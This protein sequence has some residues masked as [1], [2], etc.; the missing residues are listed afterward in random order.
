M[1]W[2]YVYVVGVACIIG[3]KYI[4]PPIGLESVAWDATGGFL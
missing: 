4:L 3:V 1:I 2:S